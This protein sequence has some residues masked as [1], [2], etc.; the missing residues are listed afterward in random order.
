MKEAT[1]R[2]LTE[3]ESVME[4]EMPAPGLA[5]L[6]EIAVSDDCESRCEFIV[7]YSR[8]VKSVTHNVR[9]SQC[10]GGSHLPW[11]RKKTACGC[12]GFGASVVTIG[13][14]AR[15]DRESSRQRSPG[16]RKG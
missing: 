5:G 6:M 12:A 1:F 15:S 16:G 3:M 9:L 8:F 14:R 10:D 7:R 13:E 11:R 2:D 4:K